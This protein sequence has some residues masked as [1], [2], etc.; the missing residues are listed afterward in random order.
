[1]Y[2]IQYV[3]MQLKQDC[4]MQARMVTEVKQPETKQTNDELREK[5]ER[6]LA[7][8]LELAKIYYNGP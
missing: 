1:M 6:K 4:R 7:L 8:L 3:F 2:L 5:E